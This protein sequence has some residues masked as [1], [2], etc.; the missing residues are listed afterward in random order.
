MAAIS[1]NQQAF[2]LVSADLAMTDVSLCPPHE[3]MDNVKLQTQIIPKISTFQM[4]L[5]SQTYEL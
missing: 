5:D 4:A 1:V 2:A 3:S